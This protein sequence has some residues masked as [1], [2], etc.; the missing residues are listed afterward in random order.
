MTS[1]WTAPRGIPQEAPGWLVAAVRRLEGERRLDRPGE[2]L[3]RAADRLAA[4]CRA[5]SAL[6]GD[7]LGH[8]LHPLLTDLPLGAW[9][10]ASLLDLAGGR[11]A[12]PAARLLLAAGVAAALPTAASGLVEWRAAER[13]ERRVG[14]VHAAGNSA[15]LALYAASLAAR[16]RR[17][18]GA[19]VALA[20]AGGAA[21]TAA[22]YL[23]GHLSI[24]RKVGS[25]DP[26]LAGPASAG[27]HPSA[28][29]TSP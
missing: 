8:A 15:A 11:R 3:A 27:D 22:G 13:P 5:E 25:A 24:A 1:A 26:R 17:R 20:L 6:R 7:W 12:R 10:S 14:V 23:G 2:A 19:G 21:A 29:D 18:H 16:L 9:M 4:P 28:R